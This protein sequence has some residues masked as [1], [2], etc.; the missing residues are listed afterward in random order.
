MCIERFFSSVL[1]LNISA[2]EVSCW[3]IEI[4][5]MMSLWADVLFAFP[6]WD[7]VKITEITLSCN[8]TLCY[9]HVLCN[10]HMQMKTTS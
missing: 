7:S 4:I 5:E 8:N 2:V 6:E 1:F 10:Q 3:M 9:F